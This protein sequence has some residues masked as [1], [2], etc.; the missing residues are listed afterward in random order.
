MKVIKEDNYSSSFPMKIKC[1]VIYDEYGFAYGVKKDFCGSELEIEAEDVKKHS[2][3]K[4]PDF[5]GTD[6]G[7]ICPVCKQFVVIDKKKI[8]KTVL[9]NAKEILL[10]D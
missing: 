7:V 8:P 1:K 6:Y 5:I 3:H 4:Y 2:W 9:E 10:S